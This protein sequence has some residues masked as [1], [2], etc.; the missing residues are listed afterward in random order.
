MATIAPGQQR[1]ALVIAGVGFGL[2]LVLFVGSR[3]LAG[4]D[5]GEESAPTFPPT[6]APQTPPGTPPAGDAGDDEGAP[7]VAIPPVPDSFEALELRDP[8]TPPLAAIELARLLLPEPAPGEPAPGEPAPG[9]PGEPGQ[10]GQPGQP[11]NVVLRGIEL[12][13]GEEVATL[14]VDGAFFEAGEGDRFG[15]N[16]EFMVVSLDAAAQCGT[17]LFG[18]ESFQLCVGQQGEPAPGEIPQK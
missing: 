6:S 14:E 1:R 13:D 9:E 8:F 17:F 3:F 11:S 18:D 10:P 16:D 7:V 12:V 4:G 2:V 15:P 5:G